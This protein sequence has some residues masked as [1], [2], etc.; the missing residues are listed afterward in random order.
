MDKGRMKTLKVKRLSDKATLP[1]RSYPNDA[2]LD[3]VA[4][5]DTFIPVGTTARIPTHIAVSF[6]PGY[7]AQVHD[8]SGCALKGLRVGA[9]VVDYG[10]SGEVCVIMHNLNNTNDI[11]S[12][13]SGQRWHD[14]PGYQVK[15]G[16]R[17]AQLLVHKIELP[18]VEEI[19]EL[20]SSERGAGGFNSTGR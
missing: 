11:S 7:Y 18:T 3:L 13:L 5:E 10:Y 9:G 19:D 1:R 8:R 4:A 12:K 17:V 20:P 6:D 2:G 15:A 16:D 14:I